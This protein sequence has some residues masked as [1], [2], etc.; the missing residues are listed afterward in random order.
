MRWYDNFNRVVPSWYLGDIAEV[1]TV[2]AENLP[3]YADVIR[4]S[5]LTVA[6][7][8]GWT[9]E[10]APGFRA[11]ITDEELLARYVVGYTPFAL[12]AGGK[13]AGF[14]SL[15][16]KGGGVFVLNLLSVAPEYRHCGYGG[17]LLDF[18]KDRVRALGGEKITLDYIEENT[19]LKSWYI[20]NGFVHTGTQ[21]LDYLP[22]TSG[23]M[24]WRAA[25]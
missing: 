23:F 13:I 7:D 8:F 11:Y 6:Q 20:A 1:R 18:C 15:T 14:V 22:F 21:K 3:E 2:T 17:K 24:E 19:R 5:F 25:Q 12:F 9:R 4:R 16:D 10:T